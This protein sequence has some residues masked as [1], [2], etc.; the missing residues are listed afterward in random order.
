MDMM[1][2][3]N[4]IGGIATNESRL[5]ILDWY[6]LVENLYKVGGDQA[7]L[8]RVEAFLWRGNVMAAIAEFDRRS[9]PQVDNFTA[10]L[11]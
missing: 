10:V 6:H 8:A 3:A 4:L 1:A 7:L 9:H 11:D 2:D 5:E